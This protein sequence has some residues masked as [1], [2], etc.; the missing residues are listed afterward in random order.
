MTLM[1]TPNVAIMT[2]SVEPTVRTLPNKTHRHRSSYLTSRKISLTCHNVLYP[3]ISPTMDSSNIA[4][5]ST[6]KSPSNNNRTQVFDLL[7]CPSSSLESSSLPVSVHS[8]KSSP[9]TN[10]NNHKKKFNRPCDSSKNRLKSPIPSPMVSPLASP[11]RSRF[12]VSKVA[13]AGGES[14]SVGRN[15]GLSP[16]PRSLSRGSSPSFFSNSRF[17]VTRVTLPPAPVKATSASNLLTPTLNNLMDSS[18]SSSVESPDMEVKRYM[19]DS[20]SSSSLDSIDRQND[21]NVSMSSTDS[22][23]FILRDVPPIETGPLAFAITVPTGIMPNNKIN[24]SLS[25]L[26][27][28]AS[29]QESLEIPEEDSPKVSS[30]E[31]TLTNSPC[32]ADI[33]IDDVLNNESGSTKIKQTTE[34]KRT[35]KNSW[36]NSMSKCDSGYPATLDKLFSLF[37]PNNISTLFNRTSPDM[38]K[39]EESVTLSRKES[40]MGGLFAWATGGS[41]KESPDNTLEQSMSD[42]KLSKILQ[43]NLSLDGTFTEHNVSVSVDTIPKQFKNEVKENISPENTITASNI[44]DIKTQKSTSVLESKPENK[45]IFEL[46]DDDSDNDTEVD[47]TESDKTLAETSVIAHHEED[48]DDIMPLIRNAPKMSENIPPINT[49]TSYSLGQI[50]RDSLSIIKGGVNTSQDSMRSLDSLPEFEQFDNNMSSFSP[51]KLSLSSTP[52][53]TTLTDTN[54]LL[55]PERTSDVQQSE[56]EL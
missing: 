32:I 34:E 41:R 16:S 22:F 1:P 55:K 20:C 15:T 30:N 40:P 18:L 13:E 7:S 19:N 39:K 24:D 53:N 26:E 2:T 12:Q 44:S 23:D 17:S 10:K 46:G 54:L 50:A 56:T 11:S 3:S 48:D 25:S 9:P 21:L 6:V 5:N 42:N 43:P 47:L 36:I 28:S 4:S 35:R 49:P 8:S 14:S 33:K 52:S 31:G 38:V 27:I 45:V 29:S 51:L 37:Q